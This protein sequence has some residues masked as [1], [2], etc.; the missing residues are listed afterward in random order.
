MLQKRRQLSDSYLS[1]QGIEIGALHHPLWV[2]EKATVRYVDRLSR[3]ELRF[4]Y[5][6]LKEY[7]LVPVKVID[8]GESLSK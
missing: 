2:S 5:P 4:H 6:E 3:E 1:G 8:D 7:A